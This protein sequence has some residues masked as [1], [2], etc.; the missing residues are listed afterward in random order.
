MLYQQGPHNGSNMGSRMHSYPIYQD[1]PEARRAAGRSAVPPPG[2]RLGQHRQPDRA[3][4]SRDGLRQLLLDARREAGDRARLQLAGRRSGL[5]GPPGRRA[6]ATTTGCSR[7]A[8]D[9]AVVGK[10]I[11]VNDYP[12]T[13]VGVSAAG[14]AGLD[15]AQSPQIRVPDPDEAG[16][17]ARVGAGCTWT[18]AR[19][20]WVQVFARLKPGYTVES[21]QAPLQGLFTQIRAHEM[22]LPAREGLVAVLARAVHEGQLRVESAAMGYSGLRNDF[23]TRAPRAD[24]HGRPGAAHRLRQRREPAD[25]A[26]LHAAE[27]NRRA[28]V[29]RRVARS[30]GAAAARREPR[31][32]VRRRRRSASRLP[33]CSRAGCSRSCRPRGSRC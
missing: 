23:S 18:T 17:G 2:R 16:D 28:A 26:R 15:P 14:F 29:A 10:K 4:R 22:T 24:V 3:R 11:L 12:M 8:R 31:A 7:F 30:A 21:A 9:P 6:R 32:V 25:R 5:P 13:I 27:G 19:T 1:Y 33:S 20:R